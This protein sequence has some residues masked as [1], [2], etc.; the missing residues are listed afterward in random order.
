V[1]DGA[2]GG[3]GGG[4]AFTVTR[5]VAVCVPPAPFAVNVYVVDSAGET[6]CD[7]FACTAPTASMLTSVALV[8]CHV[9]V[10]DWP[11][12]MASGFAVNVALGAG[13]GGGGG[14]GGGVVFL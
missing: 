14:G 1:R 11:L 2:G 4:G 12:S 13:A 5:A 3:G 10:A 8:V 6:C 9:K 7:P